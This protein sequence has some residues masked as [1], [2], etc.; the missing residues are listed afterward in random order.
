MTWV[1]KGIWYTVTDCLVPFISRWGGSNCRNSLSQWGTV[2]VG[3][4]LEWRRRERAW[5]AGLELEN[6]SGFSIWDQRR[7]LSSSPREKLQ[8]QL[9][10][11]Q[12]GALEPARIRICLRTP[13]PPLRGVGEARLDCHMT[14]TWHRGD[15]PRHPRTSWTRL[16]GREEFSQKPL[17]TCLCKLKHKAVIPFFFFFP[18]LCLGKCP[19]LWKPRQ[20]FQWPDV[21]TVWV[22]HLPPS[23]S[24]SAPLHFLLNIENGISSI[25]SKIRIEHQLCTRTYPGHRIQ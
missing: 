22:C 10:S 6:S 1:A 21:Q 24:A 23:S 7:W 18:F 5:D 9:L 3:Y 11:R 8:R 13:R 19:F 20:S 12:P 2:A 14:S 4:S 15:A 25:H 17:P 16:R